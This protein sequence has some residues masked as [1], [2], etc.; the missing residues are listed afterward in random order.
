MAV[1]CPSK[2]S[3]QT[4]EL[5]LER[6]NDP[7]K[8]IPISLTGYSG[9]VQEVLKFD[10]EV[11][12]FEL[13]GADAAKFF[14]SGGTGGQVQGR[15]AGANKVAIFSKIYN[16]GSTRS[17][18]HALANDVIFAITQT[19]GI[20]QS[21]I[22]F[23]VG[24]GKSSEICVADY[25]GANLSAVTRDSSLVSV[26]C[27]MPGTRNLYYVSYKSGFPA[28]LA[29]D[30]SSGVRKKIAG[31]GGSNFSPSV[32]P[33]GRHLAMILSKTGNA[34]LFV[35][36]I[37]GENLKQLTHTR[38]PESSP[39]WSPD[40]RTICYVSTTSGRAR[41]YKIGV[42]GGS[43]KALSTAGVGGNLTEP[44]WS[45][46]GKTIVFTSQMSG[47]NICTVP[48]EGGSVSILVEGEDP[49]WAANSRTV[50]FTR[51]KTGGRGLSLL[52]VPTKHVKDVP[53][54]SGSASQACWA[55]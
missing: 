21:L 23:R 53:R 16:G 10:L 9:T 33:D 41:L 47:F 39:C 31:Y 25:D 5:N 8:V 40:N 37:N 36:D 3:A 30:L 18:A 52:D 54:I 38:E 48:A 4:G 19:K 27:W 44:D 14:L 45:P 22:A 29:H 46:D 55:K 43:S 2:L 11:A 17:Q 1:V 15:L 12:G 6:T 35:S 13:V 7:S 50:I 24:E 20:A 42:D 32:S 34:E 28:I 26:P 49:A 51:R